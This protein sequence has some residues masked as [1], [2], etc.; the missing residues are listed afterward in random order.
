MITRG[1]EIWAFAFHSEEV[2]KTV[3]IKY[4]NF[5]PHR[6]LFAFVKQQHSIRSSQHTG[7]ILVECHRRKRG[8]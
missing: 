3:P 1:S 6:C 7:E 4:T 2:L 8:A 5:Y